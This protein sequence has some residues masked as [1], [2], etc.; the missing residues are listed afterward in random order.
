MTALG[1]T[2]GIYRFWIDTCRSIFWFLLR[3]KAVPVTPM[4]Q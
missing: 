2:S 1:A 4:F 3:E